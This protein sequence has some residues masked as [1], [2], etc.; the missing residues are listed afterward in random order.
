MQLLTP[1]SVRGLL[2]EHGLRP[3]RAL[4]QHFLADP[5]TARRVVRLA[6]VGEGDRVLE[7]GPGLG[8]LTLA[9]AEAGA[10]VVALEL[11]RHL[12]PILEANLAE[13]GGNEIGRAHV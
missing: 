1:S 13:A 8:S 3:S 12:A 4:G 9:L 5:N 6:G 7:I 11:D 10:A 2:A